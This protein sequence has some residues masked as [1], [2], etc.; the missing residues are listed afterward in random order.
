MF[1]FM[2][3]Q[4][5]M[6]TYMVIIRSRDYVLRLGWGREAKAMTN[7]WF[8]SLHP[9]PTRHL[10]SDFLQMTAG[11]ETWLLW[12]RIRRRRTA[13]GSV[14]GK[15]REEEKVVVEEEGIRRRRRWTSCWKRTRT[16]QME[17]LQEKV[18]TERK[19]SNRGWDKVGGE[20]EEHG[21]NCFKIYLA[22]SK[23]LKSW[24]SIGEMLKSCVSAID[25]FVL[26]NRAVSICLSAIG[27]EKFR[28]SDQ[29][30]IQSL[31]IRD[32]NLRYRS[33]T[34]QYCQ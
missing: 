18:K 21:R 34:N 2:H 9:V 4:L 6:F 12:R 28:D 7:S 5:Y 25:G 11:D 15:I 10:R 29:W 32:L 3:V 30:Q 31:S 27:I 23:R 1:V 14:S 16:Q 22:F 20:G 19:K 24:F 17:L 26:R 8:V 33:T 13:L